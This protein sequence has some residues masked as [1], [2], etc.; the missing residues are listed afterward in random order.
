[1]S[2][3]KMF[4]EAFG[5]YG[6]VAVLL[7][8]ASVSFGTLAPNS[9]IFQLLNLTGSFGLAVL[10]FYRRAYPNL[11]LNIIWGAISLVAI[12]QIILALR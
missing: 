10:T 3:W 8:Y 6:L 5:W 7:A 12:V 9:V 2:S 1:M 11:V 4:V